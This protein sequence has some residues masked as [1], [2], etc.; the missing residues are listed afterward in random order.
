MIIYLIFKSHNSGSIATND[1]GFYHSFMR[2]SSPLLLRIYPKIFAFIPS[3]VQTL[4]VETVVFMR[5]CGTLFPT[6]PQFTKVRFIV[7]LTCR[8]K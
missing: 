1:C 7:Q 5:I 4:V 6:L 2:V 8:G 3:L